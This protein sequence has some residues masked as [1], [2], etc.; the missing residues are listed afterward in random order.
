[1]SESFGF[2]LLVVGALAVAFVVGLG[3]GSHDK[4]QE[5]VKMCQKHNVYIS[6]DTIVKCE[7]LVFEK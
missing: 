4:E 7:A 2:V 3:V 1:M 5:I 6:N